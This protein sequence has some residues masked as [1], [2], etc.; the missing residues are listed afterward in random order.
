[1]TDEGTIVAPVHTTETWTEHFNVNNS[2]ADIQAQITAG[3]PYYIEP[4]QAT[5]NYTETFDYGATLAS[6]LIT[7]VINSVDID[8]AVVVTTTIRSEELTSEL[9]SRGLI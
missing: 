2:F 3:Y 6:T 8:G 9:Q 1:M 5:G 7:V 4:S